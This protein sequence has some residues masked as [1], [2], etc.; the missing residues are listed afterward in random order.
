MSSSSLDYYKVQPH[1]IHLLTKHFTPGR[2]GGKIQ[3][4]VRH[5]LA[6]VGEVEDAVRVWQERPASAHYTVG[7]T[8]RV[9]QAVWDNNTAWA[10]ANQWMNQNSIAI[11]HSNLAGPAQG[12]PISSET[13]IAGARWA[14]ALCLYYKLGRPE[15]GKNIRD[16]REFTTTSCPGHLAQG[17]KYHQQWMDEAGRFYDL[18]A[19]KKV[20]GQGQLAT[21]DG[22]KTTTTKEENMNTTILGGVSAA[23]LND[24]KRAAQGA[25]TNTGAIL[26]ALKSRRPSLIN[27]DHSFNLLDYVRLVD[28]A[29]WE[30]R[31]LMEA[32]AQ[33]IGLDPQAVVAEAI[34]A[35]N[36]KKD[37]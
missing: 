19:A 16:H 37:V 14:A 5:H 6:M 1:K 25:E 11:E 36:E 27:P 30:T 9:G 29:T 18:L 4:I 3:Y 2:A 20:D 12:Y 28:A 31:K 13:I 33:K 23:A 21:S 26:E 24:A 32:I 22:G 7:P 10:N 8:G 34:K 15:F 17:G 35:D